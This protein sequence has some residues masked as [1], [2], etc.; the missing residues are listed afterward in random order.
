[1]TAL[2]DEVGFD[3]EDLVARASLPETKA[4]LKDTTAAAV[5]A[6]VFGAPSFIVHHDEGDRLYWGADRLDE[7]CWASRRS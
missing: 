3:G 4:M 7:V 6:G 1:V 2:C 5:E